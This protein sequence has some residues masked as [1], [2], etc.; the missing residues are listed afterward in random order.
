MLEEIIC[1][2]RAVLGCILGYVGGYGL[3]LLLRDSCCSGMFGLCVLGMW[4]QVVAFRVNNR[5]CIDTTTDYQ[6]FCLLYIWISRMSLAGMI[7]I[8]STLHQNQRL[9]TGRHFLSP[10]DQGPEDENRSVMDEIV[11]LWTPLP[12]EGIAV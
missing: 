6:S 2:G 4:S 8:L 5:G 9:S 10:N 12:A 1:T 7:N 3:G 11:A